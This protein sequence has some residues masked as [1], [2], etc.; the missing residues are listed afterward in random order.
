MLTFIEFV[1]CIYWHL[2]QQLKMKGKI[3]FQ[4]FDTPED[5]NLQQHMSCCRNKSDWIFVQN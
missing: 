5:I 1:Q 4:P 2:V 3:N